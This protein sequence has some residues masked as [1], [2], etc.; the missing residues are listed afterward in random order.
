MR[1]IAFLALIRLE[2]CRAFGAAVDQSIAREKKRRLS[3]T[4][5]SVPARGLGSRGAKPPR[6]TGKRG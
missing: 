1:D 6:D 4:T 5:K 2:H 3:L